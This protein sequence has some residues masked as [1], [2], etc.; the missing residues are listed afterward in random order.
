M[1]AA[2]PDALVLFAHGARD[3]AWGRSLQ[4]LAAAIAREA[5]D[6]PVA[7]AFLEMQTPALPEVID[8]LVAQ[9]ARRISVLPVFWAGA[10]H[11]QHSLP[12]MLAQARKRHPGLATEVLPVLSELPG[13]I[14]H[15]AAAA[16]R[17]AADRPAAS[18]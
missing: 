7:I 6:R 1:T 4:L 3:P 9:G 11:V 13:L 14:D 12:P 8:S 16:V 18:R 2:A 10:G 17:M 15:V 5:P